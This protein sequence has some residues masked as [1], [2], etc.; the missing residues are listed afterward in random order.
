MSDE[1]T[2]DR[3]TITTDQLALALEEYR[4]AGATEDQLQL[5][6]WFYH[7]SCGPLDRSKRRMAAELGYHWNNVWQ[8]LTARYTGSLANVCESIAAMKLRVLTKVQVPFVETPITRR[9]FEACDYAKAMNA[10]VVIRGE[11]GRS[12]S[13]SL[14]EWA[15]Q[16]NH[17]RSI[18]V[19]CEERMSYRR[20]LSLIARSV[21]LS[22]NRSARGI[23]SGLDLHLGRRHTLIIDEAGHLYNPRH[24]DTAAFDFLRA[25]HDTRNVGIVLC[26]TNHYWDEIAHGRQ[27]VDKKDCVRAVAVG[28]VFAAVHFEFID[29]ADQHV[30]QR[31]R[32]RI[33]R[34]G[35]RRLDDEGKPA[36][37]AHRRYG[38]KCT[39]ELGRRVQKERLAAL[40]RRDGVRRSD[41]LG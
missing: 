34:P 41:R 1:R 16:N 11:T 17:G 15:R 36:P 10:F 32:H 38:R 14:R 33:A 30:L 24:P 7:Y 31:R 20:F 13:E 27:V 8:V 2:A 35:R 19:E 40:C 39:H 25:I 37:R 21:S 6:E 5:V 28:P 12:K 9:I 22:A 23:R 4:K 29:P 26:F 3:L 18:Y